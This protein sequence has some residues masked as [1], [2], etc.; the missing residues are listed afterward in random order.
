MAEI[1]ADAVESVEADMSF[2]DVETLE[3]RRRE[4][5]MND[6]GRFSRVPCDFDTLEKVHEKNNIS[7]VIRNNTESISERVLS[8]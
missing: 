2:R 4:M 8:K 1:M 7:Q 3:I 5:V 6:K